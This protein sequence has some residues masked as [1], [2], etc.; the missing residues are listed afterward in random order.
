[1]QA[2]DSAAHNYKHAKGAAGSAY[3]GAKDTYKGARDATYDAA[4]DLGDRAGDAINYAG[5]SAQV[6]SSGGVRGVEGIYSPAKYLRIG[7]MTPSSMLVTLLCCDDS[8]LL[9]SKTGSLT[10]ALSLVPDFLC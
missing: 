3:Q 9:S 10:C 6:R 1:M 8:P 4:A 2:Q 5:D 7:A